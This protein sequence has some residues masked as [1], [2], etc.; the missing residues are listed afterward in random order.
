MLIST[1]DNDRT[2]PSPDE[3]KTSLEDLELKALLSEFGIDSLYGKFLKAQIDSK[4]IWDLDNDLLSLDV[5]LTKIEKLK[6]DKA[7]YMAAGKASSNQ[8]MYILVK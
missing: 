2:K 1:E 6:Y 4:I 5:G 3:P 7:K 8:G